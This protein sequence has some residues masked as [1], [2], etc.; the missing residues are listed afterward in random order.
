MLLVN[1]NDADDFIATTLPCLLKRGTVVGVKVAANEGDWSIPEN[2]DN[3]EDVEEV[4]Q[5]SN[6][7]D[8]DIGGTT[9]SEMI[10][11]ADANVKPFFL[12]D[13]KRVYKATC[14]KAIMSKERLSKCL[15]C[16]Q[17]KSQYPG[18]KDTM[19]DSSL[20]L[21]NGDPVL[22]TDPKD[23]PM[24]VN[25]IS[26]KKGNKKLSQINITSDHAELRDVQLVVKRIEC[27][28]VDDRLFWKGTITGD[29]SI[30]GKNCLPIKPSVDLEPLAGMTKYYFNMCLLRD[31]GVHLQ[32]ITPAPS[33][34]SSTTGVVNKQCF[35]C[36]KTVPLSIM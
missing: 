16:V 5:N 20:F 9:L 12:I 23:G 18:D 11:D 3:D 4:E 28:L 26:M 6:D 14:L 8:D 2:D 13:G 15:R 34:S 24:V 17:G 31:M 19:Q 30:V 29:I 35:K 10:A 36:G 21:L 32:L 33:A 22:V 27:E 1:V 7:S 25:V